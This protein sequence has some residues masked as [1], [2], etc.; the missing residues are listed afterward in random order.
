MTLNPYDIAPLLEPRATLVVPLL[1]HTARL[2]ER[3]GEWLIPPEPGIYLLCSPTPVLKPGMYYTESSY[4][5]CQP[6]QSLDNVKEALLDPQGNIVIPQHVMCHKEHYLS[7]VP[8]VPARALQ[9]ATFLIKIRISQLVK[10]RWGYKDPNDIYHYFL[11]Q[12]WDKVSYDELEDVC[13]DLI[14]FIDEFVY[15]YIWN[16]HFV[17]LT[18]VDAWVH[19]AEDFRIVDWMQQKYQ[20]EERRRE[21][22]E[23]LHYLFGDASATLDT[24]HPYR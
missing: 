2:C 20:E 3:Y 11:P 5:Q 18:G 22:Q 4:A 24:Y 12:Y 14:C 13:I 15:D 8:R 6:I 1:Q 21:Q 9:L 19:R 17:N 16:I 23:E 10:H 7:A